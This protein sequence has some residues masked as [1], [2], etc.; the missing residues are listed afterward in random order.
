M[1]C[2]RI[3][4]KSLPEPIIDKVTH[5]NIFKRNLNQSS[6]SMNE[7]EPENIVCK[8]ADILFRFQC[9]MSTPSNIYN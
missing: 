1:A 5:T 4:A 2:H 8:M 6:I 9:V 7:N 3:G